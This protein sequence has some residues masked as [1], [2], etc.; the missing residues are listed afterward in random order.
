MRKPTGDNLKNQQ[1]KRK[2]PHGGARP[3]G[4]RP[5]FGPTETERSLVKALRGAGF[6]H[7]DIASLIGPHGVNRETL[8]KYFPD[9]LRAGKAHIDAICVTGIV[10]LMQQDNPAALFFY[11]KTRLGWRETQDHHLTGD[12]SFH[13]SAQNTRQL[14]ERL[15]LALADQPEEVKHRV[16]R[17]LFMPDSNVD[18]Q[19]LQ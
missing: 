17:A 4:G 10:R 9:E 16:A 6:R 1:D 5:P 13:N 18:E 2:N 8:E 11:A 7:E 14:R 15:E 3:D 12:V 19:K